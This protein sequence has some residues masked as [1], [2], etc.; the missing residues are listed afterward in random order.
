MKLCM[1]IDGYGAAQP[2]PRAFNARGYAC[3]HVKTTPLLD[4]LYRGRFNPD[5]Y[6]LTLDYDGNPDRLI[7]TMSDW[8]RGRGH[9]VSFAIPGM[10]PG[11]ELADLVSERLGIPQR[12]GTALSAARRNKYLMHETL[13]AA[14]VPSIKQ[15]KSKELASLM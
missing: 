11:V 6:L 8:C 9:A 5:D 2:L 10:E 7:A 14:G 12:N 15:G 4:H 1:I 13:R 3:V